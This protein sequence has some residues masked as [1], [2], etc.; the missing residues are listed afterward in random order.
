MI[1]GKWLNRIGEDLAWKP[2]VPRP[3]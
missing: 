3:W 2:A 1:E